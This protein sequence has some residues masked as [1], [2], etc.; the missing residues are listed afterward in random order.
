MMIKQYNIEDKIIK[1]QA[2]FFV[3]V[4]ARYP[5]IIEIIPVIN[6]IG[7]RNSNVIYI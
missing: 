6:E 4:I 1:Y 2:I 7:I 5:P 3:E